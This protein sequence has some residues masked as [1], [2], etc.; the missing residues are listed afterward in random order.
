MVLKADKKV[1]IVA[2]IIFLTALGLRIVNL[3]I[4]RNNP[5]FN[6]PIMDEKYHDEW[7]Q[8]IANGELFERVPF[9]RAPAY[10]YFLGMIYA[11]FGHSF[12][13]ARLIGIIIGSLSC[14][15]IFFIGKEMYSLKVGILA[16]FLACFYSMLIYF[17]SMLLTTYLE[18]FFSLLGI[19]YLIKWFK[20]KTVLKIII[21]GVFWGLAVITRPNFLIFVPFLAIYI[22]FIF[23][24]RPLKERLTPVFLFAAGMIPAVLTV[25]IINVMVGK[26]TVLLAWNGGINFYLGNNPA[27]NGWSATSP[28]IDATWW[29][30]YKDAIII[31]EREAGKHLSPSQISN[32][33]SRRGAQYIF[34][35]PIQWFGLMVKKAYLLAN[36]N[37]LSNN[38][39]ILAFKKSSPLLRFSI[40]NF[41]LITALGIFGFI[42]S[43]KNRKVAITALFI[44][45]YSFGLILFFI[46]ARYRM[47]IVP[48]LIVFSSYSIYWLIDKLKKRKIKQ[49]ILSLAAITI[50]IVFTNTDFYGLKHGGSESSLVYISFGNRYFES[51]E[52]DHAIAEY[53]KALYNNPHNISALNALANTHLALG[54]KDRALVLYKQSIHIKGNVDAFSK[55]GI[56]SFQEGIIDSAQYYFAQALAVDSTNPQVYY[57]I[58]MSYAFDRKPFKAIENL[59]NS[60]E[61]YPDPKYLADIHYNLGKLYLETGDKNKA[62]HHLFKAGVRYK[63]VQKLLEM[64]TKR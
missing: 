29:G 8:E 33:W 41:G 55:L 4:T 46:P 31:A 60:L 26:D 37:E 3:E 63:D 24:K 20:Q 11:I 35:E 1:L 13:T 42:V 48:F 5:F 34:S 9:Y 47:P 23:K 58:G 49:I 43:K 2:A 54:Q 18:V 27:A 21:S 38:Q 14:L 16:G 57:Y 22:F 56:I 30:G 25:I 53:Q 61:F 40:L 59:K 50:V 7:A 32:Y 17:D 28:E 52:Y 62:E 39:S 15:L 10:P 45:A 51:G 44:I 12:Y 64:S 36:S 6:Y 19:L